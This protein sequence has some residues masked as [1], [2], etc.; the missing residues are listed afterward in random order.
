M[1]AKPSHKIKA[2]AYYFVFVSRNVEQIKTDFRV[3]RRTVQR[4]SEEPEWAEILDVC[5][6][7]GPSTFESSN[8][9]EGSESGAESDLKRA[10]RSY[11][12]KLKAGE[13]KHTL[14]RLVEQDTGINRKRVSEWAR[15]YNWWSKGDRC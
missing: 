2:A 15:R 13:P 7:K 6:Y 12:A 4:W 5:D 10:Y 8:I 9:C 11:K 1:P 3:S 14:T